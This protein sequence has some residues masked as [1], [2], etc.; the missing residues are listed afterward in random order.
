[1]LFAT[2][3]LSPRGLQLPPL[4]PWGSVPRCRAGK[5]VQLLQE[6]G[7]VSLAKGQ[8]RL[9]DMW[10]RPAS[11]S[12]LSGPSSCMGCMGCMRTIQ[13]N[14][15]GESQQATESGG[16]A[17]P[18]G[19]L[20]SHSA[21]NST[22]VLV[23]SVRGGPGQP[24]EWGQGRVRRCRAISAG[25]RGSAFWGSSETLSSVPH[26]GPLERGGVGSLPLSAAGCLRVVAPWHFGFSFTW[27]GISGARGRLQAEA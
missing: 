23:V 27:A 20:H 26:T 22:W 5:P 11:S 2:W 25:S 15:R 18:G 13:Q 12:P 4:P 7:P 19:L 24:G 1:M 21:C 10:V 9:L 14:L 17:V 3:G 16:I 6:E 8:H